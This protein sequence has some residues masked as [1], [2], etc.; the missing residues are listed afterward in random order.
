MANEIH[1]KYSTAATLTIELN[2]DV[3]ENTTGLEDGEARCSTVVTGGTA[4]Q[5]RFYYLIELQSDSDA[6][7]LVEFYLSR[8]SVGGTDIVAGAGAGATDVDDGIAAADLDKNQL[9]FVHAQVV[10]GD[11]TAYKGTFVVDD[12]TDDW[13][14]IVVNETGGTFHATAGNHVIEYRYITPEVQ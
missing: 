6:N 8:G 9:Q 7:T 2:K 11:A 14:L 13:R 4:P 5:V 1:S 3:D 12:P 10:D